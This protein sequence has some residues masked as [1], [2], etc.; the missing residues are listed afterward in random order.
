LGEGH[1]QVFYSKPGPGGVP[2]PVEEFHTSS[3]R[4]LAQFR[5]ADGSAEAIHQ[6]GSFVYQD[7][8]RTATAGNC[9]YTAATEK[10]ILT[11][12]PKI[13]DADSST[14]GEV[15]EYDLI[16]KIVAVQR[17]VRSLLK[18]SGE[19]PRGLLT[20]SSNSSSPSIVTADEMLYWTDQAKVRYSGGVRL[21][22][23]SSQ[24][25]A[26]SLVI[27]DSGDKVEAEGNVLHLV[28]RVGSANQQKSSNQSK[29]QV[30]KSDKKPS[31]DNQITIRSSR[32]RYARSENG[33]HYTG[34]VFLASADA[35][36][37]ADSVD[38]FLDSAGIK[39]ERATAQGRL[40]VTVSDKEVKGAE[41]EYL[42]AAGTLTVTGSPA[43]VYDYVRKSRSTALRLTY[44]IADGRILLENR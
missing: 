19:K 37:W 13:A 14:T 24:L 21:L 28:Q 39:V 17:N 25:Q 33:L 15:V 3:V 31:L 22:S 9:D 8:T 38:A 12:H 5:E 32:L 4:I 16:P 30:T 34:D 41:G 20:A 7:P 35:K 40:R 1:V 11:D 2:G 6:S 18:S 36:I 44:Y 26:E 43:E 10:L 42:P 29:S 27:L 23:L